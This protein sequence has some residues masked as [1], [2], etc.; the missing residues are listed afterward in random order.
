MAAWVVLL[1][2]MEQEF[3]L[4]AVDPH[5]AVAAYGPVPSQPPGMCVY[6]RLDGMPP[7]DRGPRIVLD[8]RRVCDT[9]SQTKTWL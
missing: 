9:M 7:H 8:A 2:W 6:W 5:G 1:G 3:S 4:P